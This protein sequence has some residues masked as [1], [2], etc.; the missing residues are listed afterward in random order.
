MS[1]HLEIRFKSRNHALVTGW[2]SRQML[3]ELR[4]GRAPL[5]STIHRAWSTTPETARELIAL[6]EHRGYSIVVSGAVEPRPEPA[7]A[8]ES[9]D[10]GRGLW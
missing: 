10:P 6:A 2:G 1:R 8:S 9:P 4:N 5:Y 3:A 7:L